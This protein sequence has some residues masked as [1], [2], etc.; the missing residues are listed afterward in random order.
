LDLPRAI[1]NEIAIITLSSAMLLCL[2]RL[3]LYAHPAA[4]LL[5][6]NDVRFVAMSLT[7]ACSYISPTGSPVRALFRERLNYLIPLAGGL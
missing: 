1:A 7:S 6:V 2:R 4:W 3:R 5:R